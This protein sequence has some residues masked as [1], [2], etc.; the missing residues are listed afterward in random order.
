MRAKPEVVRLGMKDQEWMTEVLTEAFVSEPLTTHLFPG[1]KHTRHTRYFMRGFCN[2]ALLFGEC[3]ST[4]DRHGVA[5]WL[6]PGNTDM[7]IGK[8]YRAGML[9]APFHLGF[10]AFGRFMDFV[11]HTARMHKGAILSPH[12]YL[13]ALGV[14]PSSQGKGIGGK[15]VRTMLGRA[16]EENLPTYLETQNPRNVMFYQRLGFKTVGEAPFPKLDGLINWSM[17]CSRDMA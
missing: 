3:Y 2:Y 17:L 7:P 6:L 13:F 10:G 15:L 1:S 14:L 5:L 4:P 8:I 11:T 12:Y 9:S 16:Q